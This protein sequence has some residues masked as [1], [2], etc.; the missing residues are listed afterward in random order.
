MPTVSPSDTRSQPSR[1]ILLS[2]S[3]I[4]GNRVLNYLT[5]YEPIVVATFGE[6]TCYEV[7]AAG[8][9]NDSIP[10][11]SCPSIRE[12]IGDTC[13]FAGYYGY[14]FCTVCGPNMIISD[15]DDGEKAKQ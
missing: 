6:T 1:T 3:D 8:L 12:E 4:C 2:L 10:M 7:Y 11:E 5:T 9:F 13:C 15:S 14:T